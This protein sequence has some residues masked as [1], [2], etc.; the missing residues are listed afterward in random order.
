MSASEITGRVPSGD[1]KIFYRKFGR[2]GRTPV[3]I[4]HGLSFFSYDWAKPAELIGR[5]REVAAIDMR[6]FGEFGLE[7]AA[8]L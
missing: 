1:V 7:P 5:D 4:V 2:P 3:L 8:R 6:G